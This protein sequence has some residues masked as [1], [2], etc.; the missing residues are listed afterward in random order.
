MSGYFEGRKLIV[1][2]GSSG[3]GLQTARDVVGQGASAVI[4]GRQQAKVD[5]NGRRAG[6]KGEAWGTTAD[7]ADRKG[8]QVED[9]QA[10]L[11]AEHADATL[12]VNA[13]KLLHPQGIPRLQPGETTTRTWS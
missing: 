10:Q 6:K 1:V 2:G 13:A 3:M 7:L 11:A 9:V 8:K 4:V 12:L 5:Q